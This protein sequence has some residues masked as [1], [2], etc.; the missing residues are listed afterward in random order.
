VKPAWCGVV[1]WL[2][3]AAAG[4]QTAYPDR[5][6]TVINPYPSTGSPDISG[7]PR[8][9]KLIKMM[10]TLS[11]PS[12]PD[13]LAQQLVFILGGTLGQVPQLERVPKGNTAN[14][15]RQA[16]RAPADG[17]TLLFI[18]SQPVTI[19]P[20]FQP[21]LAPDPLKG[22]V[23]VALLARMPIALIAARAHPA[24]TVQEVIE[25]ARRDPGAVTAGSAGDG[26]TS[27]LTAELFRQRAAP[28]LVPVSYN[29]SV[30]AMNA[31]ITGQV[32]F[33]F[34]P[35]AAVLPILG[36]GKLKLLGIASPE[37][38]PALPEIPTIA[39][40]GVP[41]FEAEGWFGVFVTAGTGASIVSLLNYQI[42]RG[43]REDAR[44]REWIALGLLPALGTAEEFQALIEQDRMLWAG[45]LRPDTGSA[46][47]P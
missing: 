24:R 22:L 26:T 21:R 32:E 10:Q 14:G 37:R 42:N 27:H 6:L 16:A 19:T 45:L 17:H 12:L 4:A 35:L 30:P 39:E 29:G 23:P 36:G 33:G 44:R 8:I 5:P 11:T 34:V 1:L 31:V 43:L 13:Q 40:S 2:A 3:A 25:R 46:V 38:H 7:T 20:V 47:R 18:G 28:G 9:T 41:G 15:A